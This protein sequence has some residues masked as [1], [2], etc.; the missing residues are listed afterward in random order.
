[1]NLRSLAIA[2][3]AI[4]VSWP[5]TAQQNYDLQIHN[6]VGNAVPVDQPLPQYPGGSV[7]S[8]QEGWV[9]L[10]FVVNADGQ[11]IDPI[12]VD[13][14]GGGGF[15]RSALDAVAGGRFEADGTERAHN[16]ADIRFEINRGRDA[17]TSNFMRRYYRVVTHVRNDET[18]AARSQVDS[19]AR[20]GGWNLYESTMLWLMIGRVDGAEGNNAEKLEKYRRALSISNRRM[21]HGEDRC[22]LLAR[23]FELEVEFAQYAAARSTFAMLQREPAGKREVENAREQ[24]AEINALLAGSAALSARA[25]IYDPCDCDAGE[26]LWTYVPTRQTFSFRN[27]SGNVERFEVR[28]EHGRLASRVEADKTWS[29]PT[30]DCQVFVFGDDG[31][32]F[33]FVEHGSTGTEAATGNSAV[34]RGHVLD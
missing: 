1:M 30:G 20:L 3:L 9:R 10:S 2:I 22:E 15:V 33:E 29:L 19:A 12:I 32:T 6:I 26:P 27:L 13:S 4:A 8:G 28:C 14:S 18:E 21:L 23:M 7:R 25:T 17:A 24:A 16:L 34:A 5:A 31:A 11:A